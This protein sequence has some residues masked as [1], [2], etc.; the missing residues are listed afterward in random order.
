MQ[1]QKDFSTVSTLGQYPTPAWACAAL[2]RTHLPNLS[3]DDLVLEP[4]CGP[5]RFLQAVPDHVPAIGVEIDP[6][7]ADQARAYTGRTVITGDFFETPL[8][9]RPTVILG[10][11]PFET[12]L[13]ERLLD[14]S[15]TLLEEN[16]RVLLILPAYFFQ[17]AGRVVRYSEKWS[18]AQEMIPRNLYPGLK[19]PLVFSTFTKD[20]KRLMIGMSLYYELDHVQ[21]LDRETREAL[22]TGPASWSKLVFDAI[23]MFGGE[24]DL[25]SIYEYVAD[26]RPSHNPHWREQVRKVC[27]A[28]TRRVARGRYATPEQKGLFA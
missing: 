9:E 11:P 12:K 1:Y 22:M 16:E 17:T 14:R 8:Q 27:Q 21:Q 7:L 20:Q 25:R 4:M 24:A 5:G 6:K 10:N 3:A 15:H 23:D 28:K 2:V 19:Y 18:M 13:I 26:R